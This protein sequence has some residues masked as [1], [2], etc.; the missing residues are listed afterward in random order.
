[1]TRVSTATR[2]ARP[3]DGSATILSVDLRY[4]EDVVLARQR[5][6]QIAALLGFEGQD[7]TRL[8]TAVSEIARNAFQ[9]AGGG[10]VSFALAPSA[11]AAGGTAESAAASLVLRV[12]DSGPGI[13]ELDAILAGRYRSSTGMGAGIRGAR[14]LTD[15]FAVET[16]P[17]AGTRVVMTRRVP[18]RAGV[19]TAA[20]PETAAR[21]AE[22]LARQVPRG[23]LEEVQAQNS[24]LLATLDAL[25]ERQAD[26]ERLNAA[27]AEANVD[28]A[29]TNQELAETN[30]G[31][32]ALYAELDDRAEALRRGS[33]LKSRFL[34]DVS[35]ELRTPLSSIVNLTRILVDDPGAA[36]GAEQRRAVQFIRKSALGLTELVNDLLDLAKIEAGR[37]ELRIAE[38]TVADLLAALRGVCRPLVTSDAVALRIDEPAPLTLLTDEGRLSQVLRNLVG[39]ALKYTDAGE[40]RVT[41]TREPD[42]AVC[43]AVRDTGV[44]IRPEDLERV[45]DEFVQVE[46]AH[47]RRVKGT[48]LGLPLSRK[49]AGLLGGTVS[50][51]SHP[52]RGSEFSLRVPRVHPS[53]DPT[54]EPPAVVRELSEARGQLRREA[55]A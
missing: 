24:E 34:S 15:T 26:V 36:F 50:L 30:R 14:R 54:R 12:E 10:R 52:G 47:Q 18:A 27:L 43:F 20:T 40:V 28:L 39:N 11:A 55:Q 38:F 1:M 37:V 16:A 21:L 25:R 48:G 32:L 35:H 3:A 17:G 22:A 8:A 23:P 53:L 7:Q 49:L 45:F 4:A 42:D 5:A 41:T 9:Y 44:G 2:P 29:R 51:A 13:A 33:E 46:G 31:V 19:A 6:R